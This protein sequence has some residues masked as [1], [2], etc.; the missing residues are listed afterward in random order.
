MA[1]NSSC[2]FKSY[3]KTFVICQD[4]SDCSNNELRFWIN[5]SSKFKTISSFLFAV[6][7]LISPSVIETPAVGT[8]TAL[9]LLF[10]LQSDLLV[11][12]KVFIFL[13]VLRINC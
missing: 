1:R 7:K 3:K 6:S 12:K 2:T 5:S 13:I 11:C 8:V 10:V 4:I 9:F